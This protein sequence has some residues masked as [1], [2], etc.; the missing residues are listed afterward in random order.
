MNIRQIRVLFSRETSR[1]VEVMVMYHD[2]PMV[3]IYK[4]G[5]EYPNGYSAPPVERPVAFAELPTEV[6]DFVKKY[7]QNSAW[8]GTDDKYTIFDIRDI[9]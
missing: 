5:V 9:A 4:C 7:A 2:T 3:A 6:H 8:F 1:M